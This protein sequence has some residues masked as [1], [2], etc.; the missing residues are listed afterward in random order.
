MKRCGLVFVGGGLGAVLRAVILAQ[1]STADSLALVLLVNLIGSFVLGLVFVLADEAGLLR[2]QARFFLAVGVLGGFTT[3]STF[4]WGAD[5]LLAHHELVRATV[6]LL[7][8]ACGGAVAVQAG[9]AAGREL[10][11]QL[12]RSARAL[13]WR[14][15]EHGFRREATAETDMAAIEAEDRVESA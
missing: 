14:L 10:V 15:N 7:G 11:V 6:Y 3:F 1:V 13:L 5:V 4:G 9:L 8:S 2:A 12:E